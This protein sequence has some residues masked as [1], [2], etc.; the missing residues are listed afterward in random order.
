M[1]EN[2]S[3]R[4][5]TH[6]QLKWQRTVLVV[7]CILSIGWLSWPFIRLGITN[8]LYRVDELR[9]TSRLI[10][11]NWGGDLEM[12]K[13]LQAVSLSAGATEIWSIIF[14]DSYVDAQKRHEYLLNAQAAGIDTAEFFLIPVPHEDPKTL[15]IA[16]A[17][18]DTAHQRGWQQLTIATADLHSARSKQAYSLAA[19]PYGISVAVVGI[20]ENRVSSKNWYTTSTGLTMAFSETI[21][22][23]Y[24]DFVVL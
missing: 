11:E 14:E 22:K 24:Y 21:K 10:V 1:K 2:A 20:P 17:V 15:N 3:D 9:P 5:R 6:R 12:F 18:A 8:Y 23:L 4:I 16:R 13:N 19:R 7:L